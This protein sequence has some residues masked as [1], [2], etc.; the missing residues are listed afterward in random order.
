MFM[1]SSAQCINYE[2]SFADCEK[3]AMNWLSISVVKMLHALADLNLSCKKILHGY[4]PIV[5]LV[6][7]MLGYLGMHFFFL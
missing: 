6:L 5:Q 4:T 1:S 3:N 2:H 7:V